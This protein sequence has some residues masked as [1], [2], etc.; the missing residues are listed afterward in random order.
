MGSESGDQFERCGFIEQDDIIDTPEAG[1]N[2]CPFLFGEDGP[3]RAFQITDG[4]VTVY[5]YDQN[6]SQGFSFLQIADMTYMEEVKTAIGK[7]DLLS[8]C[9]EIF[10]GPD[11]SFSL[12]N[13]S[14]HSLSSYSIT[15][16]FKE[17][18]QHRGG[19]FLDKPPDFI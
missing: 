17:G 7:N 13:L 16:R 12:L 11:E 18:S 3:L 5:P 15:T 19:P 8:S 4:P 14:L 9:L 1:E 2:L 10:N 6:I